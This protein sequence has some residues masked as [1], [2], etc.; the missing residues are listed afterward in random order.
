MK[1]NKLDNDVFIEEIDANSIVVNKEKNNKS[2]IL[3]IFSFILLAFVLIYI[4]FRLG[5]ITLNSKQY[6]SGNLF[7][8]HSNVDFGDDITSFSNYYDYDN[9]FSYKFSVV[10]N[11]SNEYM[12][13]VILRPVDYKKNNIIYYAI[14]KD[15]IVLFKGEINAAEPFVLTTQN[16]LPDKTDNYELRL[17]SS[18]ENERFQ[19]KIDVEK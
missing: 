13:E 14:I 17:W 10:N 4:L 9:G 5:F 8:V 15:E 16:I 6:I 12:Y 2:I 7:V 1:D 19:F 18:N 11:N 3:V